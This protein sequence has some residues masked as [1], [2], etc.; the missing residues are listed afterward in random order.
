MSIILSGLKIAINGIGFMT[1]YISAEPRY[2]PG[3]LIG[4][5]LMLVS[6]MVPEKLSR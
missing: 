3:I 6:I 2:I 5:G 4:V 1:S